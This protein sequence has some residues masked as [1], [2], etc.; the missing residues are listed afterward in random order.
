MFKRRTIS[1]LLDMAMLLLLATL[2]TAAPARAAQASPVFTYPQHGQRLGHAGAHLFQ[3]SAVADATGYEWSF[4]QNGGMVWQNWRDEGHYSGRDYGIH[5]GTRSHARLT[6]GPVE[7]AVR[8][9]VGGVW[10]D[11][12]RQTIFL[13]GPLGVPVLQLNY[14]P[15][16]PNRPEYLSRAETGLTQDILVTTM[17]AA[18]RNMV[19]ATLPL[20]SDAT[21]YHGALAPRFLEYSVL[22]SKDFFAPMP[23]GQAIWGG[24]F[25]PNYGQIM[26]EQ[27]ICEYVDNRGV[28]EVWI[29]GYHNDAPGGIEPD[30]SRMSSRY[31]DVSN[32]WP[33]EDQV[34]SEYQMPKCANS[35]VTYN[36]TYQASG[37]IS[38]T[39]HNRMH[40]I[41]NAIF[42]AENRGYPVTDGNVAG[43]LFW[44]D[45]SVYGE[46]AALPGY[47]ASCGN[48]HRPPNTNSEYHYTS[49]DYGA[50]NCATWHPNDAQTT[51]VSGNCAQWNCTATGFY[52]WFMQNMPGYTNGIVFNGTYMRNWWEAMYDFNGFIDR[53]RSLYTSHALS[54]AAPSVTVTEEDGLAILTVSLSAPAASNVTVGY[55]TGDGSATAGSDYVATHGSLTF[56]PSQT[57]RTISIPLIRDSNVEGP[58]S[59]SVMLHTPINAELSAAA[60][61]NVTI[62]ETPTT[63]ATA[64]ATN[65]PTN[66]ATATVTTTPTNTPTNTATATATATA[67]PTG[68][69]PA[70][71][72]RTPVIPTVTTTPTVVPCVARSGW[73]DSTELSV[74]LT[75]TTP[76]MLHT[77]WLPLLVRR[78]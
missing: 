70:T 41:E 43:S 4:F 42:Y 6:L 50:N 26:R 49:Q 55:S 44:D 64:T 69:P 68:T 31:G 66:T 15:R 23:R 24:K 39:I 2:F 63:T 54:M 72:T 52:V 17:Q 33:K 36:F 25:R 45:F 28:K 20:I 60:S 13:T 22:D 21:R 12:A 40:Q 8:A 56:T 59:F 61:M 73:Q 3:V 53:G 58:E 1:R 71:V 35:Y 37:D 29:Y 62:I 47:R 51:Y 75:P 30:E 16:D 18:T 48:T 9:Q 77:V 76:P 34:A 19:D 65:T 32:S 7:V 57:S 78:C 11:Y 5:P 38:N 46:R 27:N 67:T 14:Y 74:L 10:T